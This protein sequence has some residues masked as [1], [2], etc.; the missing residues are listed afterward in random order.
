MG[1]RNKIHSIAGAQFVFSTTPESES[2]ETREMQYSKIVPTESYAITICKFEKNMLSTH[3][4]SQKLCQLVNL[5]FNNSR[6]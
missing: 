3:S 1:G 5:V 2:C 6:I 4:Y